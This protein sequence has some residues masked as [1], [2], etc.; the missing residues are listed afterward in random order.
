MKKVL[1]LFLLLSFVSFSHNAYA[2]TWVNGYTRKDGTNVRGHFRSDPD[3]DVSNN[4]S[5]YGN[6]NPYT[7]KAGTKRYFDYDSS[8][9][10]SP[11]SNDYD[12]S[13]ESD[14]DYEGSNVKADDYESD[15]VGNQSEPS[16]NINVVTDFTK[17][18][19]TVKEISAIA[20]I[21]EYFNYVNTRDYIP[22]YDC[23]GTDWQSKHPYEKFEAGYV[24]VIN[25]IQSIS[26]KSTKK[27]VTLKVT[28]I[29]NEGWEQTQHQY[30]IVY[31][32]KKIDGEWK[33]AKGKGKRVW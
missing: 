3:G 4:W 17:N 20:L 15:Y 23:W 30:D 1:A 32:V 11:S 22:A 25:K 18:T 5:T 31:Q 12:S 28:I 6:V 24:D 2:D 10:S 7:G 27:R 29:A 19:N 13:Y 33:I 16:E 26:T 9:Y 8:R 21:V 14:Y